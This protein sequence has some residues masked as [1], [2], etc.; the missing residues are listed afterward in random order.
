MAIDIDQKNISIT[1]NFSASSKLTLINPLGVTSLSPNYVGYVF[2]DSDNKYFMGVYNSQSVQPQSCPASSD[3]FSISTSYWATFKS[4]MSPYFNDIPTSSPA[5]TSSLYFPVVLGD[6]DLSDFYA[7]VDVRNPIFDSRDNVAGKC[8]Q[9][10]SRGSYD[11]IARVKFSVEVSSS[12]GGASFDDT[13]L[14]SA[15]LM[16][17][18]TLIC[19]SCMYCIFKMFIN[20]RVRG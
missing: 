15:I 16:I 10:L 1:T 4:L 7:L 8:S 17:P 14:I 9:I 20:K 12:G 19:L 11:P 2:K 18:A 3:I 5:L 13:N 6:S